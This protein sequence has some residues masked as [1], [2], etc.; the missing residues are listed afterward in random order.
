MTL[1]DTHT[2]RGHCQYCLR[3][4][5]ID[6]TTGRL[7]KHGYTVNGGMFIG[8]C[9][10]SD[11]LSLHVDRTHTD[12][13]IV[14]YYEKSVQHTLVADSLETGST[15]P[16]K[17]AIGSCYYDNPTDE[18]LMRGWRFEYR[19]VESPKFSAKT[20]ERIGTTYKQEAVYIPFEKAN[21]LQKRH[22]LVRALYNERAEA[23][24]AKQMAL[25]MTKWAKDIFGTEA[26]LAAALDNWAK[27]GDVVHAGG[28]KNGFEA[29]VEGV[30]L[31]PY[32]TFG[33]HRGRSTIEAPHVLITRPA[34]PD[35]LTNDG[36]RVK[37]AGRKVRTYWE[38]LRNVQPAE[39]SLMGR[40]KS[41]G[42]I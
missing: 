20:G 42:L 14:M 4:I 10:G 28:K 23:E 18:K 15:L 35:V 9:P 26:Y 21:A 38:P 22:A 33:F 37:K 32:T 2:H 5:A 24:Q 34:I 39:D 11:V 27:V 12:R 17:A 36:K 16:E 1:K 6:V 19:S 29:K 7:A 31:R 8:Q 25:S 13:V 30:E 3:V 40:L 41:D